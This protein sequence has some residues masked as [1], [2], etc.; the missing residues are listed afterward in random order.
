MTPWKIFFQNLWFCEKNAINNHRFWKKILIAGQ[1][2][3]WKIEPRKKKFNKTMQS[4]NQSE[5][6]HFCSE[7]IFFE[8]FIENFQVNTKYTEKEPNI[9]HPYIWSTQ[10][11]EVLLPDVIWNLIID[12]FWDEET[13]QFLYFFW[14]GRFWM[15]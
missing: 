15:D 2:F 12:R 6:E 14:N 7:Y 10:N 5:L 9:E 13:V 11:P 3:G 8:L 4:W 1:S